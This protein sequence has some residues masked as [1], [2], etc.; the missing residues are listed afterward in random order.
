MRA[1][2]VFD[3]QGYLVQ[4]TFVTKV[5]D[6]D[7][8]I[9]EEMNPERKKVIDESTAYIMTSLMEGVVKFGTAQRIRAGLGGHGD[10]V[11]VP[12]A[13]GL[14]ALGEPAQAGIEPGVGVCDHLFLQPRSR[15]IGAVGSD[16]DHSQSPSMI[17]V[18]RNPPATGAG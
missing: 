17:M 7:G 1:Y 13:H 15:Q 8:N 14:L 9:L 3:N 10:G 2:S 18:G 12:V 4:P 16:A 11:L 6:R 5:V